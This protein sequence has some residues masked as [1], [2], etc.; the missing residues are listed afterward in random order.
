MNALMDK[1]LLFLFSPQQALTALFILVVV[2]AGITLVGLLGYWAGYVLFLLYKYRKREEIS[3][4]SVLLQVSLP[5]END[6]KIDSAEQ[7]FAG[8]AAIRKGGRFSF[9]S[10]QPFISFEIVAQPADIRFYVYTPQ[11]YRDL[12]EKQINGT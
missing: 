11:K 6:Y 1:F 3:L 12:V 9:L 4:K 10:P 2:L 8:F 7:M 5:R